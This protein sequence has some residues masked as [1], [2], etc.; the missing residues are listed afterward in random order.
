MQTVKAGKEIST[1]Q[2]G[3]Q[4]VGVRWKPDASAEV[5]WTPEPQAEGY[6]KVSA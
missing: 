2:S 4:R 6:V 5:E 1:L 3:A